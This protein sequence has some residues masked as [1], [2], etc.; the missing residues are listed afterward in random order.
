MQC[1]CVCLL[2]IK[3]GFPCAHALC[4]CCACFLKGGFKSRRKFFYRVAMSTAA[5]SRRGR[6]ALSRKDASRS[7]APTNQGGLVDGAAMATHRTT[8]SAAGHL[9]ISLAPFAAALDAVKRDILLADS[10]VDGLSR[11]NQTLKSAYDEA[12]KKLAVL[13]RLSRDQN[14]LISSSL[15]VLRQLIPAVHPDEKKIIIQN[16]S[17]FETKQNSVNAEL[18]ALQL[19]A[20]QRSSTSDGPPAITPPGSLPVRSDQPFQ[21]QGIGSFH[22]SKRMSITNLQQSKAKRVASVHP[23]VARNSQTSNS[24]T[25]EQSTLSIHSDSPATVVPPSPAGVSQQQQQHSSNQQQPF[26]RENR[27]ASSSSHS[28]FQ[29]ALD[30][31]IHS[32]VAS[33]APVPSGSNRDTEDV[34]QI[35]AMSAQNGA[36]AAALL[37]ALSK[38][39]EQP[40]NEH[41]HT[42]TWTN[43]TNYFGADNSLGT[44]QTALAFHSALAYHSAGFGGQEVQV[45]AT[46]TP[47]NI[48]SSG[49]TF[50]FPGVSSADQEEETLNEGLDDRDFF[51]DGPLPSFTRKIRFQTDDLVSS[52]FFA[53]PFGL[54]YTGSSKNELQIWNILKSLEEN[55]PTHVGTLN[56]VGS[57]YIL[58]FTPHVLSWFCALGRWDGRVHSCYKSVP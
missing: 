47:R 49:S 19:A 52:V 4:L 7:D 31:P 23:K 14:E 29:T 53:N 36:N 51:I 9:S 58:V 5:R 17:A 2:G 34:G 54:A 16:L 46:Q 50:T 6:P 44:T 55:I 33:S 24:A 3:S 42:N 12:H 10:A 13:E 56:L 57:N 45:G 32:T 35:G 48:A 18:D 38:R 21:S 25:L 1:C 28:W 41:D 20:M 22:S 15:A 37:Q 26:L 39:V 30:T 40:Q 43:E 8:A 27:S 11:E